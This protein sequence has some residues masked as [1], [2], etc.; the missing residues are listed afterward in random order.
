MEETS[1][2]GRVSFREV[3]E[4]QEEEMEGRDDRL[5]VMQQEE[6]EEEEE[7]RNKRERSQDPNVSIFFSIRTDEI[8]ETFILPI[9]Y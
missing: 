9:M 5:E 3:E 4:E 8:K 2:R 6:E 1:T 7:G